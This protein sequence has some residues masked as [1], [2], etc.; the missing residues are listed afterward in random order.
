MIVLIGFM[1]AGKTTTGRLLAARLDLPFVDTDLVI[2]DRERRPI[3]EIF[4]A[5]GEPAFRD[6]EESVVADVLHGSEAVVS[7][8]GGAYGRHRTR[9]LL[10]AHLVVHLDVSFAEAVARTAGDPHRPVLRR[11]DLEQLHAQRR[12]VFGA[13]ADVTVTTDAR[14]AED[15]A[16]EVLAH[17]VGHDEPRDGTGPERPPGPGRWSPGAT[18]TTTRRPV[19]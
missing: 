14:P 7:L 5:D 6:V 16:R 13:L 17:L 4:A 2:E 9:D 19:R 10:A 8:G 1:G 12:G 11:P 3:P 18:P 15:V